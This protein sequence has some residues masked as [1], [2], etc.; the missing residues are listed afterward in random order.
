MLAGEPPARA[1]LAVARGG[2]HEVDEALLAAGWK[3]DR[4]D[5]YETRPVAHARVGVSDLEVDAVF[6]ASPSAVEGLFL[7]AA[8]GDV[9]LLAIGP[10]TVRALE[11]AGRLATGVA[12]TPRLES[13]IELTLQTLPVPVEL[14]K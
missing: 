13:L 3:V 11:D 6:L 2:R 5:V 4:F 12:A 1:V 9:P 14:A 7:Q 8:V 10:T